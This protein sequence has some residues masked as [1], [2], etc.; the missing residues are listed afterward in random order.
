MRQLTERKIVLA[1]HNKGKLREIAALVEPLGIEVISA[2]D[3]GLEEPEETEDTFAGNARIKAHF[4]A[5]E[6]GLPALSD[7]S[8]IEI[9]ALNG[10]PGVYT[11]DWAETANGR[12]F[13]QAM[14]R[15]WTEVQKSDAKEP[16]TARFC[17]TLCLAWPDGH[18]EICAGKVDGTLL[19]PPSGELGFGYDPMFVPDGESETF[20]DMDPAKKHGMSHRADAFAKLL[21]GPLNRG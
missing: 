9:D 15:A 14:T 8:G 10:A 13:M 2:G 1:S 21:K 12:D 17:C 11:A 6:S 7:D 19:W 3:L 16:F 5:K 4:A 20:G 18:D